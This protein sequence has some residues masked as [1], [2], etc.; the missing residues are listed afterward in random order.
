M[1]GSRDIKNA[2]ITRTQALVMKACGMQ[3][4]DILSTTGMKSSTYYEALKRAATNGYEAG[5]KVLLEH[6][7]GGAL[8][9]TPVKKVVKKT[10]AQGSKG[11][12]TATPIKPESGSDEDD[13]LDKKKNKKVA[14]KPE[15]GSGEDDSL[16]KKKNKKVAIKPEPMEEDFEDGEAI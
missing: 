6:V 12:A 4:Q 10:A 5:D 16:D 13:S 14:I 1:A 9:A 15:S 8:P 7:Q 11:K 3:L 2:E